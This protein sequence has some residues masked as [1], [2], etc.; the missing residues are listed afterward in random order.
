MA[1]QRFKKILMWSC[2][3]YVTH[4]FNKHT[5]HN[6]RCTKK[7]Y[8]FQRHIDILLQW[9]SFY[10]IYSPNKCSGSRKNIKWLHN[11]FII[12][13]TIMKTQAFQEQQQYQIIIVWTH[14]KTLRMSIHKICL[15]IL[16][17]YSFS[18]RSEIKL[19]VVKHPFFSHTL[20]DNGTLLKKN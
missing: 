10:V 8:L 6:F 3:N 14:S 9:I 12:N 7:S 5:N 18:T 4:N 1:K 2:K 20:I 15:S 11:S 16:I 17:L 19:I 13:G